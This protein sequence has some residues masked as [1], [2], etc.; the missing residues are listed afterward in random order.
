MVQIE[1]KMPDTQLNKINVYTCKK[2]GGKIVTIDRD[3]GVTPFMIACRATVGC[4]GNMVSSSY[5]CDQSLTP[6]WEWHKKK[7][8][9]ATSDTRD[10]IRRG[11][12]LLRKI[13]GRA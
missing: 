13:K 12:L 8:I 7:R 6:T 2:C 1:L 11:G 10:Y 4:I 5:R 3:A 9:F